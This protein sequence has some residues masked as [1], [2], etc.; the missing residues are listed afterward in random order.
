MIVPGLTFL[1]EHIL[2]K[3]FRVIVV[4]FSLSF[5]TLWPL[6]T[7]AN[8]I[9]LRKPLKD[10]YLSRR[11]EISVENQTMKIHPIGMRYRFLNY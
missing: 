3:T 2:A 5:V 10:C 7:K 1:S 6:G 4:P 11:D 8:V 9:K